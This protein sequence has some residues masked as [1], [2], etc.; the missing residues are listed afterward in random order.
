MTDLQRRMIDGV[1]GFHEVGCA[2]GK[3]CRYGGR[4]RQF[5]S[6][7][8]HSMVVGRLVRRQAPDIEIYGLLHD[9]AE[10]FMGD[11]PTPFKT[12]ANRDME[13]AVLRRLLGVL[14]LSYPSPAALEIVKAADQRAFQSEWH[15][16]RP[17]EFERLPDWRF[18]ERDLLSDSL[19]DAASHVYVTDWLAGGG[20]PMA[21]ADR[22][23]WAMGEFRQSG[24]LD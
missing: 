7:L 16:L 13:E 21:F 14:G 19:T 24:G 20:R 12:P 18:P 2:L 4:M 8:A 5:Y 6:V 3:L 17:F 23:E 10:M 9:A 1:T 22:C 15:L 11:I